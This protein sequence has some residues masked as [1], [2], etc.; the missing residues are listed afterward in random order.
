MT[1]KELKEKLNQFDDSSIVVMW[2]SGVYG[3]IS[4]L[5]KGVNEMDNCVII[6][7]YEEDETD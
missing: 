6:D 4:H 5:A 2:C 7:N 1:V 3:I